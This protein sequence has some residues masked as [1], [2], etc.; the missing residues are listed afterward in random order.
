M[1]RLRIGQKDELGIGDALSH[2]ARD[3][4]RTHQMAEA[5][6]V[7]GVKDNSHAKLFQPMPHRWAA[8]LLRRPGLSKRFAG[9][10]YLRRRRFLRP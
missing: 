8:V 5:E 9:S 10:F 1:R 6:P 7:R 3:R 2:L 4:K